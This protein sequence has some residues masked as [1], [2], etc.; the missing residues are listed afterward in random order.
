MAINSINFS[1]K[2]ISKDELKIENFQKGNRKKL[3]KQE[4]VAGVVM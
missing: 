4:G 3:T 2:I 1:S